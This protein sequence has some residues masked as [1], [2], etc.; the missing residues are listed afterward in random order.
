MDYRDSY[1]GL[2]LPRLT[3]AVK[4]LMIVNTAVFLLNAV[5]QGRLSNWFG[6]SWQ[7]VL[8]GY[9]LGLVRLVTYQFVHDFYDPLHFL[10]NML[11]FYF[12][13]PLVEGAVGQRR[14]YHLYLIG[15]VVGGIVQSLLGRAVG[16]DAVPIVGASGSIY[17]LLVYAACMA[18]RMRVIFFIFPIELR[19]LVGVLV[20][21]GL[22]STY[23][24]LVSGVGSKT[25]HGGHLGGAVWGFIAYRLPA[26]EWRGLE[27]F[28]SWRRSR[29]LSRS[30]ERQAVLDALLE[31]I[32]REGIGSLTPAERR[33]LDRTSREMR[34]K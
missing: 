3:P 5:L 14:L 32:Q 24:E 33:F 23:V 29:E 4:T 16:A 17:C 27:R 2:A 20:F 6:A 19:W 34:R 10:L 7:A 26:V 1:G 21:I 22:Y 13:G 8:E 9:G 18:P 11:F 28:E 25:A 12:F 31:K 15:G 30:R